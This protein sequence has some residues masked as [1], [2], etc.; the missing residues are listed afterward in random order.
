M[1]YRRSKDKDQNNVTDFDPE[2]LP[3]PASK[4]ARELRRVRRINPLGPRVVVRV[5]RDSNVSDGG[6]YLPEGAKQSMSESIQA[7]VVEVASAVDADTEEETNVSGIPFGAMVLIPKTAGVR[8]P[9]DDELRV[10]E[11]REI[12]AIVDEIP[13]T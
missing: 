2:L 1:S 8:V 7:Q 6:L 3:V 9:W 10:V 4:S 13:L 11:T 5:C 12:L